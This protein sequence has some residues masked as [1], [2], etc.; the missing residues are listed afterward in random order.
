MTRHKRDLEVLQAEKGVLGPRIEEI[1]QRINERQ[2]KFAE[3][4][5]QKNQVND[6]IYKEFCTKLGIPNIRSVSNLVSLDT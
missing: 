5:V 6:T 3:L 4:Q 1:E 2:A